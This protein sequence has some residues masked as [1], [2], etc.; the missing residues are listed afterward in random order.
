MSAFRIDM[1]VHTKN[2]SPCGKID[3][4]DVA[5]LYKG[6]GYD[7]V[8]IT[9]HYYQG[10]FDSL[11]TLSWEAKIDRFLEGYREA[12]TTGKKTGLTVLLGMELRF[13]TNEND[14]LVYGVTESFLK[15]APPLFEMRLEEFYDVSREHNMLI[16]QAHP[17]RPGMIAANP[18]FLDGVEVFNGNPRHNS[19][20]DLA[21]QFAAR[22]QL[23]MI[24]GSDFHQQEDLGRGGML[25]TT[26]IRS[27]AELVA[28]LRDNGPVELLGLDKVAI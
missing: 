26:K 19:R 4:R 8:V 1:H 17:F 12:Q 13:I 23:A 25:L 14:Y 2:V 18:A 27:N 10:Y 20:N 21:R 3:A 9:D 24:S 7:A 11:G 15:E 5:R 22:H 16:Y 6:A 28:V